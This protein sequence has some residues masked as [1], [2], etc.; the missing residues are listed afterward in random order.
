MYKIK[1]RKAS[2]KLSGRKLSSRVKLSS[3]RRSRSRGKL[4]SHSV[5]KKSIRRSS[6]SRGKISGRR[7]SPNKLKNKSKFRMYNEDLLKKFLDTN[8]NILEVKKDVFS[9]QFI[10]TNSKLVKQEYEPNNGILD[11]YYREPYS[12]YINTFLNT[13]EVKHRETDYSRGVLWDEN[14]ILQEISNMDKMFDKIKPLTEPIIVFKGVKI[15][16]QGVAEPTLLEKRFNNRF[17]S[18][19]LDI[20]KTSQF[21]SSYCCI[22]YIYV[23]AGTKVIITN[24]ELDE[25]ILDRNVKLHF[26]DKNREGYG[27]P[28]KDINAG[29]RYIYKV[30]VTSDR[31]KTIPELLS[32]YVTDRDSINKQKQAMLSA[33]TDIQKEL[34]EL[35]DDILLQLLEPSEFFEKYNFLSTIGLT[36]EDFSSLLE[37][38]DVDAV[39]EEITKRLN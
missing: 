27:I 21:A 5:N 33:K 9:R 38:K 8:N 36:E 28:M 37:T 2:R 13:G 17:Q 31:K 4:S 15:N 26:V 32:E 35:Y 34:D 14:K 23:P 25:V 6:R 18:T 22:F 30:S 12:H 39:M 19:S 20:Q 7:S 1:S 16:T 10:Q 29:D 11:Q 24:N 3:R